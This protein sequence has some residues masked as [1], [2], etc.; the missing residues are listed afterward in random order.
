MIRGIVSYI[1]DKVPLP[2]ILKKITGYVYLYFY[3]GD[4]V[5]YE[6]LIKVFEKERLMQLQGDIVE[7][8]AFI[9]GGTRKLASYTCQFNKKIYVIDIFDPSA[10]LTI[11]KSG[12]SMADIYTRNLQKI[13]MTMFDAYWYNIGRHHNVVT[14]HKDSKKY[15]FSSDQKFCFA[16]IDGNHSPEYVIND[17]YIVWKHLVP[18]GIIAF[19]DYGHDL[20]QV[21]ETINRLCKKHINEIEKIKVNTIKH[22]IFIKKR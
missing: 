10:D 5:G 22:I 17:F 8:G 14:I 12:D 20:P 13:G 9:G 21:T 2:I 3:Y 11:N 1:F 6:T 18:G 15:K 16:F 4:M 7:I 19:H